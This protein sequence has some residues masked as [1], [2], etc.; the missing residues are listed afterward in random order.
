MGG[1]SDKENRAVNGEAA[2]GGSGQAREASNSLR[3]LIAQNDPAS[4]PGTLE[5]ALMAADQTLRTLR[6]MP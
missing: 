2:S 4:G 3:L 1:R 6:V 5:R